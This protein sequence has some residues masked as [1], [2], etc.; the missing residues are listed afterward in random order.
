MIGDDACGIRLFLCTRSASVS[1]LRV[2]E[3]IILWTAHVNRGWGGHDTAI[4]NRLNASGSP[5]KQCHFVS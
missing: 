3:R 1:M 5:W 2:G 4:K